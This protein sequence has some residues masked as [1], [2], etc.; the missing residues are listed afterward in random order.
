MTEK[1][2]AARLLNEAA[3][4]TLFSNYSTLRTFAFTWVRDYVTARSKHAEVMT[5]IPALQEKNEKLK[6][7]LLHSVGAETIGELVEMSKT[8][9]TKDEKELIDLYLNCASFT[10]EFSVKRGVA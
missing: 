7:M 4:N 3:Q 10:G 2:N 8:I 1:D 5:S 6:A 9:G